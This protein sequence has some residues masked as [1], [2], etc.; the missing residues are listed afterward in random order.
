[1]STVAAVAF[2]VGAAICFNLAMYFNK[3]AV[4]DLPSVGLKQEK[5]GVLKAFLANKLIHRFMLFGVIG[6]ASYVVAMSM[7]PVSIVQPI[8]SS[9]VVLLAY[10][11]IRNLGEKPRRID[12]FAIGLNIT[13]VILIGVSLAE[14]LPKEIEHDPVLFW[15][16]VAVVI[17]L[18][19]LVQVVLR[20]RTG[21]RQ[22]AALGISVG[23]L[24]GIAAVFS[25]LMI[26]DWGNRWSSS[27]VLALFSSVYLL[28]WLF[29]FLPAIVTVQAAFQRGM[30]V[31][32]VPIFAGLTQLVPIVVGMVALK[33]PLPD[34]AL[35][36]AVRFVG[37]AFIL[38]G[39]VIL[40]HRAEEAAPGPTHS[41]K[42]VPGVEETPA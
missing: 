2:A 9:G 24:Y 12:L 16:C 8:V 10:L 17:G 23:L 6:A 28:G 31:V 38:T 18:A 32:V 11:A 15:I 42:Q 22:A 27:G 33:E 14:G 13:G 7:A 36:T 1:M 41:E 5:K 20:G 3:K 34:N 37:F 26:V 4:A 29:T 21:N 19:L 30:A 35:L 25:R 39:T 40:S